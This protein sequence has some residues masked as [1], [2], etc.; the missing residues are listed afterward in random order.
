MMQTEKVEKKKVESLVCRYCGTVDPQNGGV[1]WKTMKSPLDTSG[2][3]D[4]LPPPL[5]TV[6]YCPLHQR[7]WLAAAHRSLP[8]RIILSHIALNAK[9][10]AGLFES[11]KYSNLT[12]RIESLGFEP[13]PV[14]RRKRAR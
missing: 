7:S 4:G 13:A 6:S 8:T 1:A 2:I 10:V 5:R 3:N 11:T 12:K 14:K 9:P